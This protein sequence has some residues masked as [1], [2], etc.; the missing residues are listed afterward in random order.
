MKIAVLGTRGVPASYS[1]FETCA[2]ELGWRL[3][4][5]GHQ[6]MVYC[7]SHHIDYQRPTYR[8][9]ELIK[10]PT[11]ASKH[12][13][14]IVHTFLS[15]LHVRLQQPDVLFICGVGNSILLPLV[16]LL[17]MRAAIN[18]D[19]SD[20]RRRKWGSFASWFL[21]SSER[22]AVR[23]ADELI[24]DSRCVQ[25]YYVDNYDRQTPFVPYGSDLPAEPCRETLQKFG[26]SDRGYLLVVGRLV[27]ENCIHHVIQAF[28]RVKHRRGLKLVVVGDAPYASDYISE[29]KSTKDPDII[30]TGYVFGHG[31]RQLTS[32]AYLTVVSSEVGGTHPVLLEAM[33]FGNCVVVNDTPASLEVIGQ[34][35]LSYPGQ[36]G[37][38]GLQPV[39]EKLIKAPQLVA[40]FRQRARQRALSHYQWEDVTND[41]LAVFERIAR[42]RQ[43]A[44]R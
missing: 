39:L 15:I 31:Y 23:F 28:E 3:A 44:I 29:L 22:W 6:V 30:F 43:T 19:G 9:M 41:Y 34:S 26:L 8:G 20:Y 17:G 32:R 7:R 16:R 4:Q 14:T 27:P 11:I 12:L 38:D 5:R 35:G 13:D 40:S 25:K 2:E 21:R 37:P 33:G 36:E 42:Q 10:L 18:V 24:S 1:G